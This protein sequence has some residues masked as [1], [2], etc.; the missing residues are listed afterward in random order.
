MWKNF[1]KNFSE[2]DM[3]F[4]SVINRPPYEAKDGF[5]QIISGCTHG[6]CKFKFSPMKEIET[7]IK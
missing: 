7:D 6:T 5:W 4:S 1:Y 2:L 3:H